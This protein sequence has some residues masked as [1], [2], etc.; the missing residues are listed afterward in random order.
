VDKVK[1]QR[2]DLGVVGDII[3]EQVEQAF[4]GQRQAF[5]RTGQDEK[6]EQSRRDVEAQVWTSQQVRRIRQRIDQSRNELH[7]TGHNMRCVLEQALVLAGGGSLEDVEPE[8]LRG[9]A[10]WLRQLPRSW[11]RCRGAIRDRHGRLMPVTFEHS[12]ARSHPNVALLHLQHPVM[13]RPISEF[14]KNIWAADFLDDHSLRRVS[15]RVL[16][17]GELSAPTLVAFGRIVGTS[18]IGHRLHEKVVSIGAEMNGGKLVPLGEDLKNQLLDKEYDHPPIPVELGNV[19]RTHFSAHEGALQKQF[20]AV[21]EEEKERVVKELETEA[22]ENV[23]EVRELIKQRIDEVTE[24]LRR[25]EDRAESEQLMLPGFDPEE[26]EE[27]IQWFRERKKQLEQDLQTEPRL[28]K[29]RLKLRS[30]RLF[31]LGLL[32]LLPEAVVENYR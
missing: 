27:G 18:E 7:L 8:V 19:L 25:V 9:K 15:Y 5:G 31:P 6:V 28:M 4:L 12:V 16:P 24:R 22:E 17:S 26:Q 30:L 11:E 10:W 20:D 32:Y 21:E 14:R 3:E 13:R 29:E 1:T 23:R 2:Q